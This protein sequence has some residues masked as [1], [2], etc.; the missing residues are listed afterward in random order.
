MDPAKREAFF[1]ELCQRAILE[2][3]VA[4]AAVVGAARFHGDGW[5]SG[6]GAAGRLGR[7]Q[8]TP[9]SV[10]DLASLT[11]PFVAVTLA[12]LVEQG[13]L[14]FETKLGSLVLE[15]AE[16]ASA[17]TSLELL[18]SHRA[19]LDAHRPLFDALR[20]GEAV[21][22]AR[23]LKAASER[24]AECSGPAPEGGFVPL[25][26]DLGY[27]LAGEAISRAA[28]LD[29]DE[30]VAREVH[31]PLGLSAGS[32]RQ[33]W[34]RDA[35]FSSEVAPTEHVTWR[36]GMLRGVVHDENAWALSGHA[37][38]GHAGL[39]G[40]VWDVLSFGQSLLDALNG[41]RPRS[42]L[43]EATCRHLLAPRP[44]GSLRLGFDGKASRSSAAGPGAGPLT[45]GHLGFT[46]TSLWCDPQAEAVTVLLTN[47]VCP[48]RENLGIR[49]ARPIVHQALFDWCR[50]AHPRVV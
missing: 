9:R 4:P 27:L 8:A 40:N 34:A 21:L 36:G 10:F 39:F 19:G 20:R 37:L 43:S 47:R 50:D 6:V 28:G 7:N 17:D 3:G 42:W 14:G 2:G 49:A 13:L 45:F 44:G 35:E 26:S 18:L 41:R 16:T 29:L 5:L 25:Y 38:S 30:L 12:R 32:A 1:D 22:R 33:Q 23:A 48:T 31:R 46:G 24:R 11:K 15:L